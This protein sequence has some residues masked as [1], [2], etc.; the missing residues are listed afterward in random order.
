L[1]ISEAW[2]KLSIALERLRLG[3]EYYFVNPTALDV[4]KWGGCSS[5]IVQFSPD[6]K[7]SN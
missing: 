1:R 2:L 7:I 6:Q 5:T 3:V 4:H